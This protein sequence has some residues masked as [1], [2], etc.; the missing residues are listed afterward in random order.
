VTDPTFKAPPNFT[1]SDLQNPGG[2][3]TKM[4]QL[5]LAIGVMVGTAGPNRGTTAWGAAL[6]NAI[7][8]GTFVL[9]GGGTGGGSADLTPPPAPSGFTASAAISNLIVS[10][11]APTYTMGGGPLKCRLYGAIYTTG[12]LP[13]FSSAVQIDEFTGNIDNVPTNP[14]TEWHLWLTN[15]TNAG[16]EGP[17]AGGTNGV[18]ATTGQNVTS[19]LNA[20]YLA[21]TTGGAPYSHVAFRADLFTIGDS[22]HSSI[23]FYVVTTTFTQNG[24]SVPPGVYM[25]N[26]FI[27]NGTIVNAMI[28][29]LQVDDAKIANA[30]VSK[31]LAGSISVGQYIQSSGFNSGIAGWHI[32][33]NG[34]AEFAFTMVRGTL[35]ATQIAAS[36]ID[37]T[38]L[39]VS[40]LSAITATIGTLRTASTGQRLEISDNRIR[41]YDSS[42]VLRV[43]IGDLS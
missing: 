31:L 9:G 10:C 28:G 26:A 43:K 25:Q 30:S 1:A 17:P 22:T 27:A 41:I 15:I 8:G 20:L 24:V 32:N 5:A 39:S 38:K 7:S 12:A 19:L 35:L 34:N 13:T 23:P 4:N 40:S 14:N 21:A 18:V 2:L 3:V 36:S 33:G 37:A 42:N 16:V 11:T 6:N 29:N